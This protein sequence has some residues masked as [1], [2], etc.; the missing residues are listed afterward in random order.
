MSPK[1]KKAQ[2]K[3][4]EITSSISSLTIHS[5]D[6][7]KVQPKE[8]KKGGQPTKKT[9]QWG[10]TGLCI[11][12]KKY[13][14]TCGEKSGKPT[15]CLKC[16]IANTH[17]YLMDRCPCSPERHKL[18]YGQ[19][20]DD[21]PSRCK[22]CRIVEPNELYKC[23]DVCFTKTGCKDC[24]AKNPKWGPSTTLSCVRCDN[25]KLPTDVNNKNPKCMCK[26]GD[27]KTRVRKMWGPKGTKTG[28]RCKHCKLEDD[29]EV[30][31]KKCK[32]PLK[33]RALY[34]PK[35]GKAVRCFKCKLDSDEN[36]CGKHLYC[37]CKNDGNKLTKVW[38]PKDCS[39][40]VRCK[41]CKLITDINLM[42]KKCKCGSG[43]QP[44]FGYW[45]QRPTSCSRC[46][47]DDMIGTISKMCPG[48]VNQNVEYCPVY[49]RGNKFYDGFCTAC[50]VQSFPKD[51]R[52]LNIR[53]HT[54]ELKVKD[55]LIQTF[56]NTP[57]IHDTTM[58]IGPEC[59]CTHRRR[60]DFR[61]LLNN[62]LL[63]IEV[64]EHQHKDR[65]EEDEKIRYDDLYMVFSGKFV[66]IRFNPHLYFRKQQYHNPSMEE[67]LEALKCEID[68]QLERI[69]KGENQD[70]VEIHYL[71]Y[72]ECTLANEEEDY[73]DDS[74]DSE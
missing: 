35:N 2:T 43:I 34:G 60:I 36:I 62:T 7:I 13:N 53:K 32:C 57:F 56:S 55:F 18:S 19:P 46:K 61:Y 70:L 23:A 30:T 68:L 52:S 14:A 71:F 1:G 73:E 40:P 72:D 44:S 65:D 4:E 38:G 66:F 47:Q 27:G 24:G 41:R 9:T 20:E 29:V 12:C 63:V 69:S 6:E 58:Y 39:R 31:N 17:I 8:K 59:N 22:E 45:G 49:Q 74:T 10:D 26:E 64:D 16:K 50:F 28:L 11:T 54:H 15:H 5:E 51:P 37:D 33:N 48:P 67:R 25:C 42:D 21:K 3:E